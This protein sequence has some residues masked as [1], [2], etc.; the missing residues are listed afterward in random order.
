MNI[1]FFPILFQIK[2]SSTAM[3]N[4]LRSHSEHVPRICQEILN[5]FQQYQLNDRVTYPLMNFLD[6]LLSSGTVN[7]VLVDMDSNFAEELFRLVRLEIKGQKKLYKLVA[8]VNVLCHLIQ[9]PALCPRVLSI[10]ALYL[11]YTYV[12]V[13]KSTAAKLYETIL[14]HGD[15]SGIPEEN[16]DKV[17]FDCVYRFSDSI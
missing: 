13:R 8:S 3:F 6:T 14:I 10:L 17:N 9:I 7:D 2:Y 1:K 16:I 5:I 12:H 11:G 4:F 15:C